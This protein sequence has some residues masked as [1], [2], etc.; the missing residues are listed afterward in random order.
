MVCKNRLEILKY[1][2]DCS[3]Q[4]TNGLN[5]RYEAASM[6]NPG[7]RVF[8]DQEIGWG[9]WQE[10]AAASFF[11]AIQGKRVDHTILSKLSYLTVTGEVTGY[12]ITRVA[13]DYEGIDIVFERNDVLSEV[14]DSFNDGQPNI[15][16]SLPDVFVASFPV[17]SREDSS[18]LTF[19]VWAPRP[20]R[21]KNGKRKWRQFEVSR[22]ERATVKEYRKGVC[23]EI[24]FL[25]P[26]DQQKAAY[27]QPVEIREYYV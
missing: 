9:T 20:K 19:D 7:L 10:Y 5:P 16:V 17:Q 26:D 11:E 21:R 24:Q 13:V 15:P 8:I 22:F 3:Y 2:E 12:K 25:T 27:E 1:N 18:R 4:I 23:R 14:K 6:D